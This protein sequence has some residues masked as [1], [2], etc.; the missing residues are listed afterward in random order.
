MVFSRSA[1]GLAPFCIY[2]LFVISSFLMALFFV[3]FFNEKRDHAFPQSHAFYPRC[4]L[5]YFLTKFFLVDSVLQIDRHI[6]FLDFFTNF[7]I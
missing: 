4:S 3:I 6:V 5:S 7:R 2:R 1:V